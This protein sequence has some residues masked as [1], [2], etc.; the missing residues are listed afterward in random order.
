MYCIQHLDDHHICF[1]CGRIVCSRI[2]NGGVKYYDNRILCNICRA[3]AVDDTATVLQ[4]AAKVRLS[5]DEWGLPITSQ[6]LPVKLV[7][8]FEITNNYANALKPPCG[9]TK[10]S[11]TTHGNGKTIK[12]TDEIML[13]YGLPQEHTAAILAHELC[14]VFMMEK[15]FPQL[16]SC[17]EEGICE[18]AE[19]LWLSQQRT[20]FSKYRMWVTENNPDPIYGD[21]FRAA[22]TAL[23]SSPF[24]VLMKHVKQTSRLN[25]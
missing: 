24:L 16:E 1:S 8:E 6:F 19:Y 20:P 3:S 12:K 15:N 2:T 22:R 11:I 5:F 10:F 9:L 14:H 23:S 21:G 17:V 4:I 25:P 13:V 18:L 7:N